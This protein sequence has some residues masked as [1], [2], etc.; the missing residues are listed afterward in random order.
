MVPISPQVYSA[1]AVVFDTKPLFDYAQKLDERRAKRALAEQEAIENY[2]KELPKSIN[3]AGMAVN[4]IPDYL[5]MQKEFR[6]LSN[7]YKSTKNPLDKIAVDN[8][9]DEMLLH[10]SKSK[11]K[12]KKSEQPTATL[13]D[14]NKKG[15]VDFT[16]LSSALD[17]HNLPIKDPKRKE[18]TSLSPYF[19]PEQ[20]D[21]VGTFNEAAKGI[22]ESELGTTI[23]KG[24]KIIPVGYNENAVRSI[25]E[26][27]VKLIDINPT[28][29][30]YYKG[31]LENLPAEKIAEAVA[32]VK[33]YYPKLEIDDDE[34][35]FLKL[36]DAIKAAEQ[37]TSQKIEN[38]PKISVST[39]GDAKAGPVRDLYKEIDLATSSPKR[40]KE[41]TGSPVNIFSGDAQKA[42]INLAN[43]V[44]GT[45][46]N[47][48][49]NIFVQKLSD[50]KNYIMK[51]IFDDN[52]KVIGGE[53]LVPFTEED[54]NIRAQVDV[55]GRRAV[56]AQG[57]LQ[58]PGAAPK[59]EPS[60]IIK[61][62][63]Y[64]QS[65]LLNMY[66][67]DQINQALKAGT[68]KIKK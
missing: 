20:F 60:Y 37:R 12:V 45:T 23:V 29:I 16:S 24:E 31:K 61:G 39:G 52:N 1:E 58:V 10:V 47:N 26:N 36:S 35:S 8:K 15:K 67:Q 7:K 13:A 32:R 57:Q 3:P 38:A 9:A 19:F 11:D 63:T 27:Y 34:P 22:K 51:A 21:E 49:S 5:A 59:K 41:G 4:D 28:G 55:G 50:G 43:A 68:V 42:L 46:D 40:L 2:L 17:F 64:S 44:T 25:A 56:V 54:I 62:K 6:Q 33:K 14:P 18:I 65:Q 48:Q 30:S 53:P 66:T